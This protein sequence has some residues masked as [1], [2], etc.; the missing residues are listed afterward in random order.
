M[1][2][3]GG[4]SLSRCWHDLL[5]L[6]LLLCAVLSSSLSA[7]ADLSTG[8]LGLRRLV[9][10]PYR[11]SAPSEAWRG[12]APQRNTAFL[13]HIPSFA[14]LMCSSST[15]P[16]V[17]GCRAAWVFAF[18]SLCHICAPC[19]AC[20]LGLRTPSSSSLESASPAPGAARCAPS[21]HA[22]VALLHPLS[23]PRVASLWR[24][25][26]L[27]ARPR[28]LVPR[29]SSR[30]DSFFP[31]VSSPR[32]SPPSLAPP[33][34]APRASLRYSGLASAL[35]GRRAPRP[36]D[37]LSSSAR[38]A[39]ASASSVSHASESLARRLRLSRR[40]SADLWLRL[41]HFS[42]SIGG[43]ALIEDAN[44]L[45]RGGERLALVGP[46][47]AG[48]T[49]LLRFI[50][51]AADSQRR[52]RLPRWSAGVSLRLGRGGE[53]R[54]DAPE[55]PGVRRR[56][57]RDLQRD[58]LALPEEAD[59]SE[60]DVRGMQVTGEVA[61]SQP[62]LR[63]GLLKQEG[64]EALR[65]AERERTVQEEVEGEA[66]RR[67][68]E[69]EVAI[70]AVSDQI[71]RLSRGESLHDEGGS[72]L[73]QPRRAAGHVSDEAAALASGDAS[74]LRHGRGSGRVEDR[75][76]QPEARDRR[77][78]RR[79]GVAPPGEA[80]AG[81]ARAG[82]AQEDEAQ[83]DSSSRAMAARLS[84]LLE[85][86]ASLQ[87][88]ELS[89][90]PSRHD[91]LL[92]QVL[93]ETG[94]A[95]QAQRSQP[96]G[97][98][99]GGGRMRVQLAKV[100]ANQPDILLLDEPSN[101]CDWS[102]TEY[103]ARL[104]RRLPHPQLLV[105]HDTRLL[106]Y[107][108][109]SPS[110]SLLGPPAAG[111]AG[112][113]PASGVCTHV[114]ELVSGRLSEKVAG[115]FSVF[116][117]KRDAWTR[118]WMDRRDKLKEELDFH[119][120]RMHRWR[121]L[122]HQQ[123]GK[124]LARKR[125]GDGL[126]LRT[127]AEE[128]KIESLM[129]QLKVEDER[130]PPWETWKKQRGRGFRIQFGEGDN[131]EG[132][133]LLRL[134]N[135]SLGYR[136]LADEEHGEQHRG[137]GHLAP[138]DEGR[139]SARQDSAAETEEESGAKSSAREADE[140][141]FQIVAP[142][143]PRADGLSCGA[144]G[145]FS[146][147][148]T[149]SFSA[150]LRQAPPLRHKSASPQVILRNIDLTL[151][152]GSRVAIVGPNGSG[153]STLLKVLAGRFQSSAR[154]VPGAGDSRQS[155]ESRESSGL[156]PEAGP[157]GGPAEKVLLLSGERYVRT[158]V[159]NG[160][161][162]LEQHRADIL[163]LDLTLLEAL[164]FLR[165]RFAHQQ[166]AEENARKPAKSGAKA[167]PVDDAEDENAFRAILGRLGFKAKEVN[168]R[169][170]V[171]SG[172]EKARVALAG[173]MLSELPCR[174]LLLDEP[175]NH[176]DAFSSSSLQKILASF[177]GALVVA[178]HDAA[179]AAKVA[180][181]IYLVEKE[182]ASAASHAPTRGSLRPLV[183]AISE[184]SGDAEETDAAAKSEISHSQDAEEAGGDGNLLS[185]AAR[186]GREECGDREADESDDNVQRESASEAN[187]DQAEAA[188]SDAGGEGG[189]EKEAGAAEQDARTTRPAIERSME[190]W[191]DGWV[192]EM[193]RQGWR[194]L[195]PPFASPQ[196][197]SPHASA[198]A[199]A[200]KLSEKKRKTFGGKGASGRV[201]GVK[202]L[203]RWTE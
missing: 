114:A 170:S 96:L 93:T 61:F 16:K 113:P 49:S 60:S 9:T 181:E 167:R 144:S 86:L 5:L 55:L 35:S 129:N 121:T 169:V 15:R 11:C 124:K 115:D 111:G 201:K 123:Q 107:A 80:R 68:R 155:R 10:S 58:V 203:K 62:G 3:H 24:L 162:L 177:S 133:I 12:F 77:N 44:L 30:W 139:D 153:K 117:R 109:P 83:D 193:R 72:A 40:A 54:G 2:H 48:K 191:T 168:K 78:G 106:L 70:E 202:N 118:Q 179:F 152:P 197:E 151:R 7:S 110:A 146:G 159:E 185:R 20:P 119:R 42:L 34:G 166:H 45:L 149:S 17:V 130:E 81:E 57:D 127:G 29:L 63:V 38:G 47:G 183:T 43:Q 171:L 74:R 175:T 200:K 56:R 147:E 188:A 137:E 50:K 76:R 164:R 6:L 97:A 142:G 135:A 145:F 134:S 4:L 91:L 141:G 75:T 150:D 140:A 176:L 18:L 172:G 198:N 182:T 46:N 126:K 14:S 116:E 94:F 184:W 37:W 132:E 79:D 71:D 100:L 26:W 13:S 163:P 189:R 41:S 67:R 173:L 73:P 105:S 187:A 98:L 32:V 103:I 88:E 157:G 192:R 39:A 59:G 85:L 52:G 158:K 66:R 69:V 21:F 156:S 92:Q 128:E 84:S 120:K 196:A 82:E 64:L 53:A 174:I 101:H 28:L 125:A 199:G 90:H 161:C 178:T 131:E 160:I 89:L 165:Q 112:D 31:L 104:L 95:S 108:S 180:N 186:R 27:Q 25:C 195:S 154:E 136:E 194:P 22:F 99:S 33:L 65:G 51:A 8:I 36:P 102:T 148:C 23:A 122:E 19:P 190:S 87:E 143:E 138:A 1:S